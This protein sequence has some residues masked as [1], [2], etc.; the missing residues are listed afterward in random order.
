MK[1]GKYYFVVTGSWVTHFKRGKMIFA[2]Y[3][4]NRQSRVMRQKFDDS[5]MSALNSILRFRMADGLALQLPVHFHHH[6]YSVLEIMINRQDELEWKKSRT[7]TLYKSQMVSRSTSE[8]KGKLPPVGHLPAP[9]QLWSEELC[10]KALSVFRS[11]LSLSSPPPS[12][13]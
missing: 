7:W 3:Y 12:G 4:I 11:F 6:V 2:S 8:W 1:R 5:C 9:F 13:N 10:C